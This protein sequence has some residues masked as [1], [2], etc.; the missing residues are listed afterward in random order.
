MFEDLD[1]QEEGS[2]AESD[3][4]EVEAREFLRSF[5]ERNPERVY[6][7]RQL[8]VQNENR[9]FHWITNRSVRELEAEGAILTETR[10]LSS[11]GAVKLV[12]HR[13]YRYYKREA[14]RVVRVG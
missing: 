12:W 3:P 5:F 13:G 7:S 6:F 14:A 4:V 9:Y 10:S 2:P 8:E 1:W 11:G